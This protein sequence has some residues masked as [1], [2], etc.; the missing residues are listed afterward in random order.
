LTSIALDT[1]NTKIFGDLSRAVL[2]NGFKLRFQAR[3]LSMA[4]AVRDGEILVVQRASADE[5]FAG[6]IILFAEGDSFKAHRLVKVD[7]RKNL[8]LTQ[9]DAGIGPATEIQASALMG[10]VIAKEVDTLTGTKTVPFCGSLARMRFQAKRARAYFG[11]LLRQASDLNQQEKTTV[12][13]FKESRSLWE[14]TFRFLPFVVILLP[15]LHRLHL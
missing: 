8:L 7:R 11:K 14:A 12:V 3:G 5:L 10:L 15:G 9:A 4:P 6:D 2:S 13:K 1:P